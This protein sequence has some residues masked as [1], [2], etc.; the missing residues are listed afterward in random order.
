M[1]FDTVPNIS[2]SSAL[3]AQNIDFTYG[4][5]SL[6][7]SGFDYG[8]NLA[9]SFLNAF[10]FDGGFN[11]VSLIGDMFGT[12]N[13]LPYIATNWSFFGLLKCV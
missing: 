4:S 13:V 11:L 5:I 12:S 9:A 1:G 8:D 7:M 3:Q 10:G 2:F 6:D